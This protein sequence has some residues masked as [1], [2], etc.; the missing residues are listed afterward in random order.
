MGQ[1]FT[2]VQGDQPV[3]TLIEVMLLVS[4]VL[5]KILYDLGATYP[6]IAYHSMVEIGLRQYS[7]WVQLAISTLVGISVVLYLVC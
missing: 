3:G 1:K 6:F 4:G 2:E 5:A 7:L